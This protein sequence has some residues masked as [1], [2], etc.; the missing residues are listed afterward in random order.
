MKEKNRHTLRHALDRLP[1]HTP[2]A[3]A[4]G[5]IERALTPGL[6]ERLP[7]YQPPPSVWNGL[8]KELARPQVPSEGGRERILG[9]A[10]RLPA[11]RLA[12]AASLLFLLALGYGW[13]PGDSG[14][15]ISYAHTQEVA[16]AGTEPDWDR[17]EASFSDVLNQLATVDEPELNTLRMELTELTEAK[18]EVKTMLV[19]YGEDPAVVRQLA[20][21]ERDRSDVYR[22]IIVR[23]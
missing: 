19:T 6:A 7:S 9:P 18:E 13:W 8:S 23:L 14:P 16:P 12:I 5:G 4:W 10:R 20:E 3:D 22:R 2:P 21:I 17:E 11:K 1:D 15:A